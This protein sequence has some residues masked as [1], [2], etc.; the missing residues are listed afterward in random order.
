VVNSRFWG[1]AM[2]ERIHTIRIGEDGYPEPA[3]AR[4][5]YGPK[6]SAS[7]RYDSENIGTGPNPEKQ[8]GGVE[9]VSWNGVLSGEGRRGFKQS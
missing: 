6:R 7:E 5:N 4:M 9:A 1:T 3:Q 8:S 2:G